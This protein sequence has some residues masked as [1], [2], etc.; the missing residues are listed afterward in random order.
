[1][2]D[3]LT[4]L[5]DEYPTERKDGKSIR[6]DSSINRLIRVFEDVPD[7]V[8]QKAVYAYMRQGVWFPKIADLR[9]FVNSAVEDERGDKPYGELDQQLKYGGYSDEDMYTWEVERGTMRPLDVIESEIEAARQQ[10]SQSID[11]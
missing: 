6:T 9:P 10:L 8:M 1:M 4:E 11:T 5:L 7:H 3:W 2:S